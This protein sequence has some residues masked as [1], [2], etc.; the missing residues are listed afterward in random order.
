M[1]DSSPNVFPACEASSASSKRRLPRCST[2]WP[3]ALGGSLCMRASNSTDRQTPDQLADGA[4]G[5]RVEPVAT[6]IEADDELVAHHRRVCDSQR[7]RSE[8]AAQPGGD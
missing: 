3:K 4:Q 6:A 8:A 2:T 7:E 1:P 5:H